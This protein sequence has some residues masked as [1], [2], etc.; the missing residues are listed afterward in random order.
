MGPESPGAGF[1][2]AGPGS[3][4][5]ARKAGRSFLGGD[6]FRLHFT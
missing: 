2:D 5:P 6:E 3:E 4:V 1:G